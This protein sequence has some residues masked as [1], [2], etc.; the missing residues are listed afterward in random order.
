MREMPDLRQTGRTVIYPRMIVDHRMQTDEWV[1]Q[2]AQ[3]STFSSGEIKGM[4]A[5][6]AQQ[7]A[8]ALAAGVSVKLEGLGTFSLR[9]G[10]S[11]ESQRETTE[12]GTPRRNAR[13]IRVKGVSFRPDKLFLQS[14]N[15]YCRLERQSHT[16]KLIRCPYTA[17]E[18][19]QQALAY[20]TD[21]PVLTVSVYATLVQLNRTQA[22]KELKA[23]AQDPESGI[24]CSGR[25]S[26][27]LYIK[28]ERAS[29]S[30]TSCDDIGDRQDVGE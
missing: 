11:A 17:A 2:A 20:L 22:G 28:Q 29:P 12:K 6:V 19:K 21:H 14:I 13:S 7:L 26:H 9:L 24:K 10:L 25:G 18:R 30:L 8:L 16:G 5:S 27:K 4:I 3:G 23:L 15:Q 1:Q